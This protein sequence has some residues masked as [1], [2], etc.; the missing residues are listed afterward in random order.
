[1]KESH[2]TVTARHRRF[3]LLVVLLA[4][5]LGATADAQAYHHPTIGRFVQRDPIGYADGMNLYE[6]GR[7]SPSRFVDPSGTVVVMHCKARR[8]FARLLK[9]RM[10]RNYHREIFVHRPFD[11]SQDAIPGPRRQPGGPFDAYFGEPT[12]EID[13]LPSEIF[14]TMI[15]SSRVFRI[16]GDTAQEVMRNLKN[17]VMVRVKT[18]D[19]AKGFRAKFADY[20]FNSDLWDSP[21]GGATGAPSPKTGMAYAA[22]KH[23]FDNS[24]AYKMRCQDAAAAIAMW[25]H[26]QVKG[27]KGFDG[28]V[29]T[30]V[31]GF[32]DLTRGVPRPDWIP[33]D[34]GGITNPDK[35]PPVGLEGLNLVYLGHHKFFVHTGGEPRVMSLLAWERWFRKDAP[36]SYLQDYRISP[37]EGLAFD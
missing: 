25:G 8:E 16:K 3:L 34:L 23:L 9:L 4:G 10:V 18:V 22:Y 37:R 31:E 30:G 32:Y 21:K 7:S 28:N 29:L 11:D 26:M 35:N 1:M 33:G 19:A 15:K 17:H 20:D 2:D 12:F 6:Y 5:I 14:G 27:D 36:R 24:S 13:R